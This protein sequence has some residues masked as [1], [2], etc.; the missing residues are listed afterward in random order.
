MSSEPWTIESIRDALGNPALAQR[1]LGEI[2]RAPAHQL[3]AVFARWERIA[4]DTLAAVEH[5]RELAAAEARGEEPGG[6]WID[7][8]DRVLADAARIRARGAA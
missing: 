4:K 8:T 1:F 6:V 3:L 2:N 5:G 7:G